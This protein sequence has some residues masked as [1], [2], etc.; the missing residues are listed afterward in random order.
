MQFR[1][2]IR[3]LTAQG[4]KNL[5][6]D[7][8]EISYVDSSGI[9]ELVSAY[10]YVANSGGTLKL[11]ALTRRVKDLLQITKLYTVFEVFDDDYSRLPSIKIAD[12]DFSTI[13]DARVLPLLLVVRG[14]RIKVELGAQDG[15]YNVTDLDGPE[16]GSAILAAPFVLGDSRRTVVADDIQ[17]FEELL[18]SVRTKEDDIQRFL[19]RH[20]RFL[21]GNE[22]QR[23]QSHVFLERDLAGP[24]VPDFML[25]PFDSRLWDVLELKLPHESLIVGPPNRRRFSRGVMDASAQL[26]EYRDYFEEKSNRAGIEKKYGIKAFRP[27]LT[28]VIGMAANV[29]PI[30]HRKVSS[31][32]PDIRVVTYDSLLARAKR[33]LIV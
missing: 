11:N 28:V 30:E 29:D 7:L 25:E 26:R 2:M 22:Y 24:L 19:E 31:A 16:R 9:G 13:K 1:D 4:I 8:S 33:F 27:R 15:V 12:G 5:K 17:E 32:L 20:P 14:S 3:G 18:N 6:L 23:V 21:M 10:T